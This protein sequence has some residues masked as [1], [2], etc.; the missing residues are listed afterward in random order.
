MERL[1]FKSAKI[2]SLP[3]KQ[4][5]V[6]ERHK[7]QQIIKISERLSTEK[8]SLNAHTLMSITMLVVC[9]RIATTLRAVSS[10]LSYASTRIVNSMQEVYAR[11]ATFAN[12]II[13]FEMQ[14]KKRRQAQMAINKTRLIRPKTKEPTLRE[15]KVE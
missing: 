1:N 10:L 11:L 8:S 12:T 5:A 2:A 9:A 14:M 7:L 13:D 6:A 3:K 4:S 15:M